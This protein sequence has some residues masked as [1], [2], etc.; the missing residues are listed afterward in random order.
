M[1]EA[2]YF[3]TG[4]YE[5]DQFYHYGLAADFYT[6]FTYVVRIFPPSSSTLLSASQ[7]IA[8][9]LPYDATQVWRSPVLFFRQILHAT[10]DTARRDRAPAAAILFGR[11]SAADGQRRS[12]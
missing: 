11:R 10:S 4:E 5:K 8:S 1:A 12:R 6:H 3:S 7:L 2:Q 9:G